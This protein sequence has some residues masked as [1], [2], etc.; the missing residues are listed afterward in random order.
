MSG[1]PKATLR[2]SDLLESFTEFRKP[3]RLMVMV[4]YHKRIQIKIG[5]GKR[6]IEQSPG[7]TKCGLLVVPS[8]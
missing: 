5:K 3:V 7:E 6:H 1:D 4:Y 8:L 2:F